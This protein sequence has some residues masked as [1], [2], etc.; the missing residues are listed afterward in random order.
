MLLGITGFVVCCLLWLP[1]R[2]MAAPADG[3]FNLQVTPSPLVA[4][5]DPGTK[6]Q[7]ELKVHNQGTGVENL[8]IEAR[9]FSV[10]SNSTN[11]SLLDT[12]PP[13]IGS[14]ISFSNPTFTLLPGQWFSEEITLA[15][16]KNAGF[17]YSF[18]LVISRQNET[19]ASGSGRL[20]QGSLA[21]FTLINVNRQGATANL[22]VTNF[23]ASKSLYE[24]LPALFSIT[25]RNKGNTILQ[26]Y[27]NLFITR[28]GSRNTLAALSV[29]ANKGY[30]LPGITR[31]FTTPWA[32]GFP[33][34]ETVSNPDGSATQKLTW[35]WGQLSS[36]RIGHYT[37]HL[38]AVYNQSGRDI[39]IEG[40]VSFWVIPWRILALLLVIS[41]LVLFALF[42]LGRAI[43]R[44]VYRRTRKH[45]KPTS[46][47][48]S[49]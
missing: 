45:K 4:T 38:V 27:G 32:N 26:P 11:I 31:T 21:V 43:F 20:I 7:L 44:L 37:A 3:D 10:S 1:S 13:A 6:T 35:N 48:E 19:A 28:S 33:V 46:S 2:A 16:P 24:Y 17:S 36:L 40:E 39:P 25:F 42:I 23:R 22:A 49:D 14:W 41:L 18:A 8:K 30:V 5:V 47:A 9:A 12:A 34:Y 29:N 15:L